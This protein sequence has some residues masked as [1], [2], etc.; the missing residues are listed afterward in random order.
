MSMMCSLYACVHSLVGV[1]EKTK[2]Q[3]SV[4]FTSSMCAL[5][6]SVFMRATKNPS[7]LGAKYP[8]IM[9]SQ[10]L[11]VNKTIVVINFPIN[12]KKSNFSYLFFN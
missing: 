5:F 3:S 2:T 12:I 4:E 1:L 7:K 8:K 6:I 9:R 10:D 11:N